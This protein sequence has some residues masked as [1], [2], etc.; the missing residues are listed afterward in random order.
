MGGIGKGGGGEC[1]RCLSLRGWKRGRRKVTYCTSA[2]PSLPAS[3]SAY[4]LF[5]FSVL[6]YA[7][8]HATASSLLV[9]VGSG[10]DT[11]ALARACARPFPTLP[12][13]TPKTCHYHQPGEPCFLFSLLRRALPRHSS[14][15]PRSLGAQ[16]YNDSPF[17]R[18][19]LGLS[20]TPMMSVASS[21]EAGESGQVAK[22]AGGHTRASVWASIKRLHTSVD[23]V[24]ASHWPRSRL[25]PRPPKSRHS[26]GPPPASRRATAGGPHLAD[27]RRPH[28]P[29]TRPT[30]AHERKRPA[31][32]R[33]LRSC[34]GAHRRFLALL[35]VKPPAREGRPSRG[36]EP[37]GHRRCPLVHHLM[38]VGSRFV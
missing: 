38:T 25:P 1:P 22:R 26:A 36:R 15:S 32:P 18:H 29:R 6:V 37:V 34:T 14:S 8:N 24:P 27:P 3:P 20:G 7:W 5:L 21:P 10:M 35:C 13:F 33:R 31:A 30:C 23:H 19:S 16:E 9:A 12:R 17:Q 2:A 28:S 11:S 4:S